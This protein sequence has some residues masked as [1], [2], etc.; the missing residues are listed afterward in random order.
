MTKSDVINSV[1]ESTGLKKSEAEN[2]VNATLEA[3][4]KGV[5]SEGKVTF[6]GFGNFT[7]VTTK[8]REGRNPAT[9][10]KLTIKAK[11]K[12]KFSP[13]KEFLS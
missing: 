7:K 1:A 11:D 9:G 4:R 3:I 5:A 8:E 6:V 12:V 13:S 2:A 10:E